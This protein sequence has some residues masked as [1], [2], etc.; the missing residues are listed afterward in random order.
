MNSFM[1]FVIDRK[2]EILTRFMEHIQLTVFS[3]MIA[4][5]IAI[6]L[7]IL[8][9]RFRKLSTPVIGFANVVQSVPSLALLGFLIPL[10]RV[11]NFVYSLSLG[12][13]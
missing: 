1:N 8:I 13:N 3:I 2:E 11:N 7:G 10:G 12:K 4:I 6:P 5:A 9:V